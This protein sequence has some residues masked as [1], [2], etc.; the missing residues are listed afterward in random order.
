MITLVTATVGPL[1]LGEHLVWLVV[2]SLVVFLVY[3]GLRSESPGAAA[4]RGVQRWVAFLG[5]TVVLMVVFGG[6]SELL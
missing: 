6:L 3:H 4:R 1:G 5:G 2:L